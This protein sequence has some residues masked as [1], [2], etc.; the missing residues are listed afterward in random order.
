MARSIHSH[1]AGLARRR[2]TRQ[3]F[4]ELRDKTSLER[5]AEVLEPKQ[6]GVCDDCLST[7]ADV[8]PRQQVNQICR[9]LAQRGVIERSRKV[10]PV[11]NVLKIINISAQQESTVDE[12]FNSHLRQPLRETKIRRSTFPPPHHPAPAA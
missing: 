8:T 3:V 2:Q 6:E 11:C 5:I 4:A 12:Y 7:A 10:C 9:G 1:I